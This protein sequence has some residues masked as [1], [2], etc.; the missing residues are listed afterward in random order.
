MKRTKKPAAP[1][2]AEAPAVAVID[3]APEA[4]AEVLSISQMYTFMDCP[5]RW[6]FKYQRGLPDPPNANLALGSAVHEAI[7]RNMAEKVLTEQDLPAAEVVE[8]FRAHWQ[9]RLDEVEWA[10]TDNPEALGAEGEGLVAK[11]MAEMAPRI[12]PAAVEVHVTGTIGG[13]KVQGH[14]DLLCADGTVRDLKTAQRTP[15]EVSAHQML[16]LATYE[17]LCPG[18]SGQ[19]AVDTLVRNKTPKLV[20][21]EHTITGQDRLAPQRIFPLAQEAMRSGYFM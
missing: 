12:H 6:M 3:Q 20:T 18:A 21:I 13:V 4:L 16:Q 7:G 17:M 2:V 14:V 10:D 15:S 1:A 9:G 5:A 19:V 11:Y 8:V